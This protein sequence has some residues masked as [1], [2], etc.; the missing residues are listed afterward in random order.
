MK[1][2]GVCIVGLLTLATIGVPPAQ[3]ASTRAEYVAQVD[4]MCRANLGPWKKTYT[5]EVKTFKAWMRL[6]NK[7]TLKAW[8]R[9]THRYARAVKR[10]V[11]VHAR[12]TA[13]VSAV[14]PPA[15]DAQLV[16]TWLMYRSEYERLARSAANAADAFNVKRWEKLMRRAVGGS[17]DKE[18]AAASALGLRENCK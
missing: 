8:E 12:L 11:G 13:Q 10:H 1:L 6:N 2:R 9:Q 16:A 4:P 7:G 14:P 17:A 15:E 5:A 3:A 18:Q